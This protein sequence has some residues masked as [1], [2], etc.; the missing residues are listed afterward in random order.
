MSFSKYDLSP[1]KRKEY[2]D[3]VTFLLESYEA[4]EP[5]PFEDYFE[6][7]NPRVIDGIVTK[8]SKRR[9][10]RLLEVHETDLSHIG[11]E[12]IENRGQKPLKNDIFGS[13]NIFKHYYGKTDWSP[14]IVEVGSRNIE[15]YKADSPYMEAVGG[16]DRKSAINTGRKLP[17][18][19][20]VVGSV[21]T[22]IINQS[23]LLAGGGGLLLIGYT[24]SAARESR[25]DARA[26]GVEKKIE[27]SIY[28][29]LAEMYLNDFQDFE[30]KIRS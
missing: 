4:E 27:D 26:R 17:T 3:N 21:A 1:C 20:G 19:L 16:F 9:V 11:M 28:Q 6:R 14:E 2:T 5:V 15:H 22:G 8:S 25:Y 29:E 18:G 7:L 30:V 23:E 13:L 12:L 24:V 10:K